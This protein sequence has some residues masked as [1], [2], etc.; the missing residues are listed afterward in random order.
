MCMADIPPASVAATPA[1][2]V[3]P[4]ESEGSEP[5]LNED[6]DDDDV[7]DDDHGVEEPATNHLV[8]AQFDKVSSNPCICNCSG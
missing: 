5:P 2:N 7:D 4:T 3:E 8:L 6:D 1:A